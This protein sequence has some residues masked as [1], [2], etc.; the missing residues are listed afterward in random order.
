MS[1]MLYF[2]RMLWLCSW[3]VVFSVVC[4]L[5]VGRIVLGCFFVMIV[6]MIC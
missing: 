3:I 1:L 4:L 6:L 2:L 5:S